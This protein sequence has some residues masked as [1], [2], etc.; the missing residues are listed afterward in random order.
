M[1]SARA[2]GSGGGPR[3]WFEMDVGQLAT[4][5][6]VR[7]VVE[8]S[9]AGRTIHRLLAGADPGSLREVHLFDGHTDYGDVLKWTPEQPLTGVQVLRIETTL[10]PS[11][12]AWREAELLGY[13]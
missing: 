12:V 3:Q 11:W 5:E 8:G 9:P 4:V 10:S 13:R 1:A 6:T 7:L 2:A